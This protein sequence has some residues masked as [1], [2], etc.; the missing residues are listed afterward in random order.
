M[1]KV[2]IEENMTETLIPV[3]DRQKKGYLTVL[4]ILNILLLSFYIFFF[5]VKEGYWIKNNPIIFNS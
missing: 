2:E 1:K 4:K 5:T 3:K